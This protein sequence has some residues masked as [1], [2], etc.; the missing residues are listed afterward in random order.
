[1]ERNGTRMGKFLLLVEVLFLMWA[2]L[3]VTSEPLRAQTPEFDLAR[4]WSLT[5]TPLK[6]MPF[7]PD[8]AWSVCAVQL[9]P[10]GNWQSFDRAMHFT[11]SNPWLD[12]YGIDGWWL[13]S[14]PVARKPMA[15]KNV[16]QGNIPGK[17]DGVNYDWPIG[18]VAAFGWPNSDQGKGEPTMTAVVWTAPRTV[19]VSVSGGVWMAGQY[20]EAAE[21]RSRVMMW[22]N[23]V[24]NASGAADEIIFRDVLV[25][26]WTD[27]Y[28]SEHP[29]AFAQILGDHASR[30]EKIKVAKGDRIA[31]G[32]YWD[33]TASKPGLNG[34]DFRVMEGP[35]AK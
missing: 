17:V 24:S 22:I 5:G 27:G 14:S 11:I 7:G 34:I 19:E 6:G 31:V 10:D 15:G 12:L 8:Y 35:E 16:G 32:F 2:S 26:L 9:K 4:D 21:H 33:G 20:E 28:D 29:E 30:L 25:P 18:R 13:G 23:R 3:L 1:M